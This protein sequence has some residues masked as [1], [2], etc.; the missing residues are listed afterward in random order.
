MA[1][2]RPVE[3]FICRMKRLA[4]METAALFALHN[5]N[6]PFSSVPVAKDS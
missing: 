1:I 4:P 3:A 2:V 5:R 6:L